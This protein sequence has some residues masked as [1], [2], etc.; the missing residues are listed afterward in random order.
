MNFPKKIRNSQHCFSEKKCIFRKKTEIS[1]MDLP[2]KLRISGGFS[3]KSGIDC[4]RCVD[5]HVGLN[6]L[7]VS[8]IP[9]N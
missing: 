2:G 6:S 1:G 9:Q 5:Y 7:R 8:S 4:D 3:G